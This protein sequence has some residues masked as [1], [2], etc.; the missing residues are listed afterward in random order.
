YVDDVCLPGSA[1]SSPTP[2]S[3]TPPSLPPYQAT[4]VPASAPPISTPGGCVLVNGD[5][6]TGTFPPWVILDTNPTPVIS[7]T[8]A[9][10]GT[11]SE[12]GRA[13]CRE[14]V[15]IA[16]AIDQTNTETAGGGTLSFWYC[17][18]TVNI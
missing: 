5:F 1:T 13:S 8:Q 12:I 6:E 16:V 9:H 15:P 18:T 14:R 10:S 3:P 17:P 2:T 7:S 4:G 11:F